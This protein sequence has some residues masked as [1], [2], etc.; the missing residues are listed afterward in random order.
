MTPFVARDGAL[1][2]V[3]GI[4][5]VADIDG[6]QPGHACDGLARENKGHEGVVIQ[7]DG[8]R[9]MLKSEP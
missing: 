8:R 6:I 4:A 2:R 5:Q 9:S 3:Y 1:P 7:R